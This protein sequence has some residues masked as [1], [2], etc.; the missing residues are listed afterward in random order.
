M[1][2][3]LKNK[4]AFLSTVAFFLILGF[5]LGLLAAKDFD[6]GGAQKAA[7]DSGY[8]KGQDYGL[9][10]GKDWGRMTYM[11][12]PRLPYAGGYFTMVGCFHK[13]RICAVR[14]TGESTESKIIVFTFWG[15]QPW[16]WDSISMV[17]PGEEFKI[18]PGTN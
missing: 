14:R 11:G 1:F 12:I 15:T 18:E 7:S 13:E 4:L 8:I 10:L 16:I 2:S 6:L 5:S 17:K 9:E 3:D